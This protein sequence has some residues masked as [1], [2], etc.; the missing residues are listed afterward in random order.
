MLRLTAALALALAITVAGCGGNPT[1]AQEIDTDQPVVLTTEN[2][3]WQAGPPDLPPGAE[4]AVLEGNPFEG[5]FTLRLRLPAGYQIP[6][7]SHSIMENVTVVSGAVH[8]GNGD[9]LDTSRGVRVPAGGFVS[10]AEG[11]NHY[12]WTEEVAVVQI[13]SDRPFNIVYVR[14]EDDPRNP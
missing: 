12:A 1:Q 8:V 14:A 7:H 6:A 11:A 10:L 9:E 13:H 4:F 3:D 2:L 5:A